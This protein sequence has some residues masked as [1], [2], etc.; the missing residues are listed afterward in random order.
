MAADETTTG[1][2]PLALPPLN[3]KGFRPT[4]PVKP[5]GGLQDATSVLPQITASASPASAY[6]NSSYPPAAHAVSRHPVAAAVPVQPTAPRAPYPGFATPNPGYATSIPAADVPE[7]LRGPEH[8]QNKKKGGILGVSGNQILAGALAASTSAV[9]ASYLGVAGTVV[10]A[11]MGSVIA[12]V[13]TA[14]YQ[15][16]IQRSTVVLQKVTTTVVGKNTDLQDAM[17]DGLSESRA[18]VVAPDPSL[19]T[20]TEVGR[21]LPDP[22]LA[23][24]PRSPARPVTGQHPP[25]GGSP[26]DET[27]P[28][29]TAALPADGRTAV[30]GA[31]SVPPP[32]TRPTGKV[33]GGGPWYADLPMKRIAIGSAVVFVLVMGI[34]T[35]VESLIGRPVADAVQHKQGSGTTITNPLNRSNNQGSTEESTSPT[36]SES[37]GEPSDSPSA[38]PSDGESPSESSTPTGEPSDG[39]DPT[40]TGDP[41]NDAPQTPMATDGQSANATEDVV[42]QPQVQTDSPAPVASPLQ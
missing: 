11:G 6:P 41:E 9:A 32:P 38:S 16:S 35:G 42:P 10:G 23:E 30:Y 25:S 15:K 36:P 4:D 12:T 3:S 5:F 20:T 28:V 14:V 39:T 24:A 18:A 29:P 21:G 34:L 33:Y 13:G 37:T 40:D 19:P 7:A 1:M 17:N 27:M 2:P 22:H 26:F 8:E 31:A